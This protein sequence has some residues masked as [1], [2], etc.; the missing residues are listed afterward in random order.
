M[1]H[2]PIT[3]PAWPHQA[4]LPHSHGASPSS[5]ARHS[6]R[7]HPYE[8]GT[9]VGVSAGGPTGD[10]AEGAG[11]GRACSPGVK[12]RLQI[13]IPGSKNACM[14]SHSLTDI[15]SSGALA[16]SPLRNCALYDEAG[17]PIH[18]GQVY[19]SLPESMHMPGVNPIHYQAP[20]RSYPVSA[21]G[22]VPTPT[23]ARQNSLHTPP[24][25]TTRNAYMSTPSS[26]YN[27]TPINMTPAT[28]VMA[29]PATS[30][31][32]TPAS[33]I[34]PVSPVNARFRLPMTHGQN[35]FGEGTGAG[36]RVPESEERRAMEGWKV[37]GS[38]G[39]GGSGMLG[40]ETEEEEDARTEIGSPEM[41]EGDVYAA[42]MSDL[43]LPLAR[44]SLPSAPVYPPSGAAAQQTRRAMRAGAVS[45]DVLLYGPAG[46][47]PAPAELARNNAC[48]K[49][50][51][52]PSV[53]PSRQ[54]TF[55]GIQNIPLA[56]GSSRFATLGAP[57]M[58]PI[59]SRPV[60]PPAG[61]A[62][63]IAG[64]Q[65]LPHGGLTAPIERGDEMLQWK[66][67]QRAK[68][69]ADVVVKDG[70]LTVAERVE[71]EK[72]VS[73]SVKVINHIYYGADDLPKARSPAQVTRRLPDEGSS[74]AD[75]GPSS[76]S[77]AGSAREAYW[78]PTPSS[79]PSSPES[80][81]TRR[82]RQRASMRKDVFGERKSEL[83]EMVRA[84]GSPGL[85]NDD[86]VDEE[87]TDPSREPPARTLTWFVTEV[88]RRSRT[89][90]NVLQVA[91]A[92]LAGAKPEIHTQ[93]RAAADRQ[94]ELALQIAGS[95]I[96]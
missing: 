70:E 7:W 82:D 6:A 59:P 41:G 93:L 4:H 22:Y 60:Y 86:S 18:V 92:Y 48:D 25:V 24:T 88:L 83:E 72:R 74:R 40:I 45:Q 31:M 8:S 9:G 53:I 51:P 78:P 54:A 12:R 28:A 96:G 91:L 81:K 21:T 49:L 23:T 17:L 71:M 36:V 85:A 68:E 87:E 20:Q 55:Y 43:R 56:D 47:T 10:K 61:I 11:A 34:S 90:I 14:R 75:A 95:S 33:A 76:S 29:T 66:E 30:I 89:S 58:R 39:Q 80:P 32:I 44:S 1:L 37:E 73:M 62:P 67:T 13:T 69:R 5:R 26:S 64:Y 65:G 79:M 94:A 3:H 84:I 52:I 19:E 38:W 42:H 27:G 63:L 15:H 2:N 50:P 77:R 16:P 46:V 57:G 35:A